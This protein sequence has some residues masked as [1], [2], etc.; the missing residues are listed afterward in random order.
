MS[1]SSPAFSASGFGD[2]S[3]PIV[4]GWDG[5]DRSQPVPVYPPA[6]RYKV[7]LRAGGGA[8][9]SRALEILVP[10]TAGYAGRLGAR[11][12]GARV[13][14]SGPGAGDGRWAVAS[15]TGYFELRG[16]RPGQ[17]YALSASTDAVAY[18]R[19]VTL[20]TSV[21]AGP[22]AVVLTDVGTLALPATAYLRVA[23]L[24]P[25]PSPRESIG[26][27]IARL[28]DGTAAFSGPLRLSSGSASTDDAGPLFGRAASTWSVVLGAPGV[29]D[30]DIDFPELGLSTRAA[31]VVVPAGGADL[32]V[33]L[34]KKANV[35]G[36][37]V[38][39]TTVTF[40]AFA[41]IQA[42][43]AGDAEPGAYGGVFISSVPSLSGPSS[44]AYS[45]FG[46]DPGTWTVL[47]RAPGFTASSAVIVV[48]GAA[49]FTGLNMTPGLGAKISGS[50]T[51]PGDT[52]AA[53][54][55]FPAAG[56]APGACPSGSYE[57]EIEALGV[58]RLDRAAVRARLG[59]HVSFSSAAFTLTG[60]DAGTYTLRAFLPGF[61]LVP[62]TAAVAAGGT[63]AAALTL[64]RMDA[65]L[66]L[67]IQVPPLPG[68]ACRST[69]S[70]RALGLQLE[71]DGGPALVLDD[72][73]VIAPTVVSARAQVSTVTGAF[74]LLNCSSATVFTPALAP[75]LLR[76]TALYAN[77]N[78]FA[79]ATARLTDG[80]TAAL[81]LDLSGSTF[82][83]SG[84]VSWSGTLAFSTR[85]PAGVPVSS[86]AGILTSAPSVSF[87]LLGSPNPRTTSALRA[88]LIPYDW[89][90]PALRRST[91]PAAGLCSA[92][93]NSTGSAASAAFVAP[94]G[95]DGSFSFGGVSPG[96]Y[97]LRVPGEL[98]DDLSDGPE[99]SEAG[100]LVTVG[101]APVSVGLRLSRGRRVSGRIT[102]PSGLANGRA[103]RV[104]LTDLLS[105]A[106]RTSGVSSGIDG[107]AYA[108]DGLPDGRYRLDVSD[109]SEPVVW[110]A[111]P[112]EVLV[113]GSDLDG[114]DTALTPAATIRARLALAR[115][116]PDGTQE[117]VLV[118][119]ENA[120]LLPRG[121]TARA[122]AVP[123]AAGGSVSARA[124]VDGSVVDSD[125]RVVIEGL[126]PGAY[127]VEFAG[128]AGASPGSVAFSPARVSGVS[129]AAGQAADLG[130]VPLFSGAA[131]SGVVL[132]AAS[133]LPVSGALVS[134]RASRRSDAPAEREG[135]AAATADGAGRYLLRGLSPSVRW[136]DLTASGAGHAAARASSVD[137]SSGAALDF[138]L[139]PAAAVLAGRIVSADGAPLFSAIGGAGEAPG[140]ALF[141]QRAGALPSDDPLA[142][143]SL[144]TDPD[145]RFS[146][147]SLATGAYRLI[148]TASGQASLTRAVALTGALT[149][150]GTLTLGG[151]GAISGVLRMPD[152]SPVPD[153]E[154]A[155]VAA[156]TPD[157]SEFIYG[158]ITRDASAHAAVA[159]KIGG[160][161]AGRVYRVLALSP[162]DEAL[163][164][165]EASA[166]V[167][168]STAEARVVNLVVRP[169]APTVSARSRRAGTRT[170]IEFLFSRPL[171][172]RSLS[173]DDAS[174][175]VTTVSAVGLMSGAAL[176]SD[177]RRLTVLYDAGV[178]ESSFTLRALAP[179]AALDYD[180][181]DPAS[182]ELV[183]SATASFFTGET[184]AQRTVV[185]NAVGGVLASVGDAGRVTLPRGAFL[186]DAS[187]SVT[188]TLRRSPTAL[189]TAGLSMTM[190]AA[191]AALPASLPAQSDFYEIELPAGV[192]SNLARPA[193]LTLVYSS[194]A[195]DPSALNLY[196]YNPGSGQ[197]ILQ[198]DALG[199]AF[200]LDAQARSLTAN[201]SHF[202]TFVLLASGA[203]AIGGAAH[204]G[205]LDA[206]N[207]PNPFDLQIKTV[208]TIH[209]AGAVAVRG[210]MVR[211]AVPPNLSGSGKVRVFDVT[212]RL[213][214]TLDM[215]ALAAGQSYYLGW[216][217]RNDEGR[218]VASGLYIGQVEI[219]S[220][221]KTFKMA[222]LK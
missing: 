42:T 181:T 205:E 201:V 144:R 84:A 207:F 149:D 220:K 219:G 208:T 7:R 57:V 160:L 202:S 212:G 69:A 140:A 5:L 203:G 154:L 20:S 209:G 65:R 131:V 127:D 134:A 49:D 213:I 25:A 40:G 217:G 146:V 3:R 130:V 165:A 139:P 114:R 21:A 133:G 204:A 103:L 39:P 109:L 96:L 19:A 37:V 23:L 6:G 173:D 211:V 186:V 172:A 66:R 162:G 155:S 46:L 101:T 120:F 51:V 85:T 105:G 54:Q 28:P 56:G 45:L 193:Q 31:A 210:T 1:F 27:F 138:A 199:G 87:C 95:A 129:L 148:V 150:L 128:P 107:A 188:V 168:T 124:A 17:A 60:L 184:G 90:Y 189:G 183:A 18:G 59:S 16:L 43:R 122:T 141:L 166:V 196:W 198:P 167:L 206:Y 82:T 164:P 68:G 153:E 92:P 152:G 110:T 158:S 136:Y 218:D 215:G 98:D 88:E 77:N 174:L 80:A 191:A 156:V 63:G 9:V 143:L 132:D 169:G 176:S 67:D 177:R 52:R 38:L 195:A 29:Y 119:R 44:G 179:T 78:G 100:A 170:S 72:A 10:A 76:A 12:A 125:G 75:G 216:D 192:P 48:A 135:A 185:A 34:T 147:P 111:R 71:P 53:T 24:V 104:T 55:C 117:L 200:A 222:V 113:A 36:Y 83:V 62:A 81:T 86:I 2:A 4:L 70:Y 93:A 11:G 115:P 79:R 180:A 116:L 126:L 145:G 118:S 33:S 121:F 89:S 8:A 32:A 94:I 50:I 112:V 194:G 182:R 64:T 35:F 161:R 157:L 14:A 58:G 13:R 151:G 106:E 214:R 187:S 47:A 97:R 15:S 171:R 108:L 26:G 102:A 178:G 99:A 22:A 137:V 159:Y 142:D 197:F 190:R 221:R 41:T 30:V 74:M 163:A 91:G 61:S 73:T 123:Y 175:V